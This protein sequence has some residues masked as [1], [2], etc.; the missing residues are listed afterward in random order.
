MYRLVGEKGVAAMTVKTS[1][2]LGKR[3]LG[4]ANVPIERNTV[5]DIAVESHQMM[6]MM[7]LEIE[8]DVPRNT[9]ER[10]AIIVTEVIVV[11]VEVVAAVLTT[12]GDTCMNHNVRV[13]HINL[14]HQIARISSISTGSFPISE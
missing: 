3:H 8:N 7:I 9:N 1:G 14:N 4:I 12:N 5:K 11:E 10:N 13:H 6:T 2:D